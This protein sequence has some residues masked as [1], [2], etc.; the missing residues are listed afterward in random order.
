[1][2]HLIVYHKGCP[3][4]FGA[5]YMIS[6]LLDFLAENAEEPPPSIT[7]HGLNHG[8]EPPVVD[9]YD[10]VWLLDFANVPVEWLAATFQ[11]IDKV[12]VLDHHQTAEHVFDALVPLDHIY[13]SREWRWEMS[14][15]KK[16]FVLDQRHSGIGLAAEYA[17]A[18]GLDPDRI[19]SCWEHLEDRDL[20]KFR[21][22]GTREV[23]AAVTSRPFTL[24]AWDEIAETT[25]DAL[26]VEGEAIQR[27]RQQIVDACVQNQFSLYLS[28]INGSIP[29]AAAP[30]AVG[31]DVGQALAESTGAGIGAYFIH[32]GETVQI[33]LRSL[34]TGPDVAEIAEFYGGGGHKHASGLYLSA[35][36]FKDLTA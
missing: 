14:T 7:L 24:Q 23:F 36:L 19:L 22:D 28:G 2:K 10:A 30:Y 34:E 20:W 21:L 16:V 18:H 6:G 29:I 35:D 33:G 9:G 11:D 26:I 27:F 3:D 1:M 32:K 8:D 12:V 17:L 13:S 4:G 31:S 15:L 25:V 5:A